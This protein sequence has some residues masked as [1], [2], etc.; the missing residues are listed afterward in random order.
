MIWHPGNL[1]LFKSK[2]V[3]TVFPAN[4]LADYPKSNSYVPISSLDD[5]K[6]I[7]MTEFLGINLKSCSSKSNDVFILKISSILASCVFVLITPTFD[8]SCPLP[9]DHTTL[10]CFSSL[11][12]YICQA[13]CLRLKIFYL[14]MTY[15]YKDR[16]DL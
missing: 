16:F 3:F 8:S 7:E 2:V 9:L 5:A 1:S 15:L 14:N 4:L 12:C 10:T 11:I 6:T 13:K